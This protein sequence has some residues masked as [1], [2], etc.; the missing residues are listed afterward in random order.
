MLLGFYRNCPMKKIICIAVSAALLSAAAVA[1]PHGAHHAGPGHHFGPKLNVM[2]VMFNL[3]GDK[4]GVLSEKELNAYKDMAAK[5]SEAEKKAVKDFAELDLNKDNFISFDEFLTLPK[6]EKIAGMKPAPPHGMHHGPQGGHHGPHGDHAGP[7]M[8]PP[9]PGGHHAHHGPHG[10]HGHH[11]HHGMPP[12]PNL[13]QFK[14][15]NRYDADH[16]GRLNQQEY[17]AYAEARIVRAE[18]FSKLVSGMDFKTLDLNQDGGI[19]GMELGTYVKTEKL[20]SAASY[21]DWPKPQADGKDK[22]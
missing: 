18:K 20:R 13:R 11:G 5:Y 15:F 8:P 2:D 1:G 9:P 22:K 21:K 16:D 12:M 19:S 7:D 10:H 14:S 17:K 3:D 6:V 4:N